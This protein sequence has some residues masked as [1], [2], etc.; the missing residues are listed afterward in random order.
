MLFRKIQL[1]VF[2]GAITLFVVLFL[3]AVGTADPAAARGLDQTGSINGEASANDPLPSLSIVIM[4]PGGSGVAIKDLAGEDLGEGLHS[5]KV[6]CN[7][8]H[9]SQKVTVILN[10]GQVNE[11]E[12]V[13]RFSTRQAFDP[14]VE[15]AV[16]AGTGTINS[17]TPREHFAFTATFQDNDDGTIAATY[18]ASRPDASFYIPRTPGIFETGN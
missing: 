4:G 11:T 1:I 9:C 17:A 15:L 2:A 12:I 18:V 16:I 13:Y 14:A 10:A 3:T 7:T 6:K 5:G 8:M